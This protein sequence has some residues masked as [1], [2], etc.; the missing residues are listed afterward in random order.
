M[1]IW[2]W[3]RPINEIRAA[4]PFFVQPMPVVAV[5]AAVIVD[6]TS[7][8]SLRDRGSG[9]GDPGRPVPP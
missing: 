4:I 3:P 2:H 5:V 7:A 1:R 6:F 9:Y 8:T